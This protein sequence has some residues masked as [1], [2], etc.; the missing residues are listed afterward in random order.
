M[1]GQSGIRGYLIQT[2]IAILESF[3]RNDWASICIEPND[4]SEK[5]DIKW[6]SE[7]GKKSVYQVK[8]SQNLFS[9]S[10]GKKWAKELKDSTPDADTYTLCLVGRL[11]ENLY[12]K[13]D[14]FD[15]LILDKPL[16]FKTLE[17]ELLSG[18]ESFYSQRDKVKAP[19]NIKKILISSLVSE[20]TDSS[21]VGKEIT[22][23]EFDTKLLGWLSAIE[24]MAVKNPYAQ[25]MQPIELVEDNVN[26]QVINSILKL[27]GWENL[28]KPEAVKYVDE[29][30]GEI[31]SYKVDYFQKWDSKLKDNVEDLIF[32]SSLVED[33]YTILPKSKIQEY[34]INTN[35]VIESYE[36]KGIISKKEQS[37]L[38]ILF[39]LSFNNKD[40]NID[41]VNNINMHLKSNDLEINTNYFFVDNARANFLISSIITA[42]NYNDCAVKFLYPITEDNSSPKKIGKRGYRLPPQYINSS[43]IPIIKET[44][45]KI[46]IMMFCNDEYSAINLKKILWL[47]LKLTSGLGNEYIIYFPDYNNDKNN[48]IQAVISSFNDELLS[49]KTSVKKLS[50]VQYMEIGNVPYIERRIIDNQEY[51]ESKDNGVSVHVNEIFIEQLPYG[52]TLKPFLKTDLINSSELKLFLG[53]KGIF[54]KNSD[55]TKIINIMTSLLYTPNELDNFVRFIDKKERPS[56]TIPIIFHTIKSDSVGGIFKKYQPNFSKVTEGISAKLLDK[57]EF[58]ADKND[59]NIFIYESFVEV[60]DP[61]KLISVNTQYYPIKVSCKRE[62][63]R[64][65]IT[66]LETNCKEGR[67]IGKRIVSQIESILFA[68]D[69]IQDE[70]IKV[71][72]NSFKDNIQRVNFLLSF[73]RFEDSEIFVE[74]D[75]KSIKYNFD[76]KEIIPSQYKDKSDKDIIFILRGKGLS[77]INEIADDSFKKSISLEEVEVNYKY[78]YRGTTGYYSVTYNFSNSLKKNDTNGEF[79]YKP[80][81]HESYYIKK[82]VHNIKELERRLRNEI[83]RIKLERFKEFSLI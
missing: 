80:Y 14:T 65:I 60:K 10:D 37:Y 53:H 78:S 13:L 33:E 66:N 34:L 44:H 71:K 68:N 39:W 58:K 11:S 76:N 69:I 83:D 32:I 56:P 54:F 51:D 18:L 25:F 75:I 41:Y 61:T 27:I 47:T 22:K 5:V 57:I 30:T 4:E 19:Y 36:S 67:V 3:E 35:K 82:N 28:T 26:N 79:N 38:S 16:N 72:F 6:I 31:F 40:M 20:F 17:A 42:K 12:N 45:D 55:K 48:E 73:T 2:L 50:L 62:S 43:I 15:V 21:I 59:Q 70:S 74:S 24:E 46:S 29:D 7:D 49:Y 23:N 64:I 8:S 9:L 1:G 77:G 81:F 63:E 52:D